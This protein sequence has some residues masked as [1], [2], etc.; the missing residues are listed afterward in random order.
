MSTAL[1]H[2]G[3]RA[4]LVGAMAGAVL[5]AVGVP[6]L[7]VAVSVG[8]GMWATDTPVAGP[9]LRQVWPTLGWCGLISVLATAAA[10]PAAWVASRR[11]WAT[12][13]LVVPLLLPSYL[14]YAAWGMVR[15]PGTWL[16]DLLLRGPPGAGPGENWY[17]IAASRIQAVLGLVFWSWPLAALILSAAMQRIDD[18]LLDQMRLDG[19]GPWRRGRMVLAMGRTGLIVA[20]A[21]V[22]LV[23]LGSVVPLHVA[24][25][26]TYAIWIWRMIDELGPQA[27]WRVWVA[28]WPL[29]LLA[30]AGAWAVTRVARVHALADLPGAPGWRRPGWR[31]LAGAGAVW[32]LS[33]AIPLIV[34]LL[35]LRSPGALVTFWRIAGGSIRM[36]VEIGGAVAVVALGVLI[37]VWL[38]AE[39]HG[40]MRRAAVVVLGALMVAGLVPGILIGSAVAQTLEHWGGSAGRWV[41]ETPG[42]VVVGH[43][44]RFGFIAALA[45]WWL[46]TTEPGS[47]R[48]LRRLDA[49]DSVRGWAVAAARGR[50]GFA[51]GVAA[52]CGILSFH[53]IEASIMLQPPTSAGGGFA[54][55]MLQAL[56]FNR[57]DDIG[58]GLVTAVGIGLAGAVLAAAMMRVPKTALRRGPRN[59]PPA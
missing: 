34:M 32:T 33:V 6:A 55:R 14:A 43:V 36:S 40:W 16:G 27:R 9:G 53:E 17:P 52:A 59:G 49:G 3:A 57:E 1:G 7:W 45:G 38:G 11:R 23:M 12:P 51:V 41:L 24:Q 58:P 54:W 13:F 30:A 29:L 15:A 19:A 50:L 46:A 42:A 26:E 39:A 5:I 25:A 28:A 4:G 18:D 35:N 56:H 2:Q 48:D 8:R 10:I 20:A 37:G 21:A 44:L 47:L 31:A 22:F